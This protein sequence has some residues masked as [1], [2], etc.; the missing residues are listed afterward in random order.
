M[1]KRYPKC[2]QCGPKNNRVVRVLS[3]KET[4]SFSCDSGQIEVHFAPTE[5]ENF[6]CAAPKLGM[7]EIGG[8][9]RLRVSISYR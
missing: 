1:S 6:D 9:S 8:L 4:Q 3:T 5:V 7:L 2:I